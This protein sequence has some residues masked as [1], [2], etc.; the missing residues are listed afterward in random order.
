M[1]F[2]YII[3]GGGLCGLAAGIRLAEKGKKTA[4]VS[5]G[6][7]ALHFCAG[8]F[9]LLGRHGDDIVKNPI[10][11][12]TELPENHPYRL[13]GDRKVATLAAEVPSFLKRAGITTY[14]CMEKNHYTLTPFGLPRP[15]WL[16]LDGY[17]VFEDENLNTLGKVLVV[18]IKG[19]LE[20]YPAFIVEN[21][22]KQGV[23]CRIETIDL[24][25]LTHLRLSNFDMRAV[26]V[27]KQIDL[28]T[29]EEF[30]GKINACAKPG[31]TVLIPA[32]LGVNSEQQMKRMRERVG[33]PL[34]CVPTIPVSVAGVRTQHALQRHFENLGGTYLLGDRVE[35]GIMENG[36]VREIITTNLGEDHL[37]ADAY[38]LASGTFF[39]E[40]IKSNPNGFYEPV[41]GLDI[42][43]P[44]NRDEW[45]SCNFFGDQPY[46]SFGVEVDSRFHP[47]INGET[48]ENLYVAGS[49]LAHCNSLKEDSGAGTAIL[50]GF[51]TADMAM[52]NDMVNH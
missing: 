8:S 31:E 5:S 12:I 25:R 33:N 6:Q 40:G 26:S 3:I 32:I 24:D 7:S 50:T 14:G 49:T 47:A 15:S 52:N 23:G 10:D 34:Y 1:K 30:A 19:F 17:P 18:S 48:I 51:H 11:G 28:A 42:N 43:F 27:A 2:E 22:E 37:K 44:E 4:I 13:I 9:G 46:M 35:K 38:I 39:S 29:I 45:Y 20:S 36:K 21:L 16:T 41:F